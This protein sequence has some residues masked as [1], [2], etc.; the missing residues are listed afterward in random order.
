M[1]TYEVINMIWF[2]VSGK[3][4]MM[5]PEELVIMITKLFDTLDMLDDRDR[6][7]LSNHC[8]T[9]TAYER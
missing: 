9:C 2:D 4:G 1:K 7:K 3:T 6:L 5:D 8:L